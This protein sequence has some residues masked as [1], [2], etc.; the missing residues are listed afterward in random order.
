MAATFELANLGFR[1]RPLSTFNQTKLS[2]FSCRCGLVKK[3]L[4]NRKVN[5]IHRPISCSLVDQQQQLDVSF[6]E[7][8]NSLIEALLGIQGR[9][10]SASPQQ[11]QV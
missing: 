11:L 8:E 2:I 5:R 4:Q 6:S 9:G 1:F 7:E 3:P 10:R